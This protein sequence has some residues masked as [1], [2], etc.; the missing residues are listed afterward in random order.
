MA[1]TSLSSLLLSLRLAFSFGLPF[2]S[3]YVETAIAMEPFN[4]L[5]LQKIKWSYGE[6]RNGATTTM[7]W[8]RMRE[9][10]K[11]RSPDNSEVRTPQGTGLIDKNRLNEL[12]ADFFGFSSQ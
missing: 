11:T 3:K 5:R 9:E 4:W 12:S 10:Q 2:L 1:K 8:L 6:D 7:E